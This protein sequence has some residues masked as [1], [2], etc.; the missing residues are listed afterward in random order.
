MRYEQL[1]WTEVAEKDY[2]TIPKLKTERPQERVSS[3][4][5]DGYTGAGLS[6]LKTEIRY[7]HQAGLKLTVF[8]PWPSNAVHS[9]TPL[10]PAHR[11]L[12]IHY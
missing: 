12:D 2:A 4:W 5:L 8:L 9:P 1:P 7:S 10:H 3:Q 11:H 6:L